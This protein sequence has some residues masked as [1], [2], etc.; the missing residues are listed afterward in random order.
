MR[1]E[2]LPGVIHEIIPELEA[3][4]L[5][6]LS[7]PPQGRWGPFRWCPEAQNSPVYWAQNTWLEPFRLEFGSI[8]E[9]VKTLRGI[10]RNWAPTLYTQFRRGELIRSQLPPISQ[11]PKAFPWLLP[12]APM[13]AFS[14]LDE[15]T[16]IG[17]A[18][19]TSP[20]PGGII[21]LVEDKVNPPSRAYRKLQE[22]LVRSR[23]WPLPGEKCLDAGACPGGWT[24]VMA[25]LG[26]EV[27]AIDRSPIDDRLLAMPNVRFTAH[28][29]FTLKPEELGPVDWL[30]SDVI[31]YPS[32]LYE[33]VE[34][35]MASGLAKNYICTI[36]MQGE[37]DRE[38]TG[39]FAAIEGSTVV[40]LYNNKHELT[41]IKLA[42][43]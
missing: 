40:H 26:A 42:K 10:Q 43:E 29:A 5:A 35:W 19:C 17:S 9:A 36:K 1:L 4:L 33:W 12:E 32:R 39:R 15:H 3:P 38:T 11:K 2:T 28:D 20:F 30:C 27:H 21:P 16:L 6:E 34:K 24:W 37:G 25:A 41:W 31:C 23:R 8:S 13:G 7:P 14:L 22:A 18:R